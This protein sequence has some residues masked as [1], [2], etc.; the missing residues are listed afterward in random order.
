MLNPQAAHFQLYSSIFLCEIG[1]A[2]I[3]VESH[4]FRNLALEKTVKSFE[5]LDGVLRNLRMKTAP[6][7]SKQ[8]CC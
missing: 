5:L 8:S 4:E 6:F 2:N 7:S 3:L 1:E